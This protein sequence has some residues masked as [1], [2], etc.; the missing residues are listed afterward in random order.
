MNMVRVWGGGIYQQDCFYDICDEL[1]IMVWQE[2]MFACA[3]YPV[4]EAFLI[5]VRNETLCQVKRLMSH[6]CIV[7]WSGNNENEEALVNGWYKGTKNNP[8]V[9]T[10]DYHRLYHETIMEA[11]LSIDHSRQF[12]SSS[13]NNGVISYSPFVE[14]FISETGSNDDYG[15]AHYYN[16]KDRGTDVATYRTPRFMSEYGFQSM[17]SFSSIKGLC[18]K[19]D[20]N[21]LSP[22]WIQRNHHANGME[23]IISQMKYFFKL[24]DYREPA[25][26]SEV[27]FDNFCYLSQLS[28]AICIKAQSEHYRR[29]RSAKS[30]CMG[31]LYWQCNDI[32]QVMH[33]ELN[34]RPQ[35]GLQS[36]IMGSGKPCIIS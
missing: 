32:W 23:E 16:Y 29:S 6:P 19:S 21:P 26:I 24:P 34:F 17:P 12:I 25:G 33:K 7:L 5:S 18:E 15:D 30:N 36:N 11:V 2:F 31:A 28:Q 8:F 27:Q 35:H 1:G 13:P 10:V 9:Y 14:R 20:W 3:M 22:F 4:D